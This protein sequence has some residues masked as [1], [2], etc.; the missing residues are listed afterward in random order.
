MNNIGNRITYVI[1]LLTLF[2]Y[3]GIADAAC[4]SGFID[5]SLGFCVM[6]YEAR[7]VGGVATSTTDGTPWTGIT[8]SDAIQECADIGAHL[9]TGQ[10]WTSIARDIEKVPSNWSDGVVGSGYLSRGYSASTSNA[11]D[12][13]TDT[14]MAPYT[15]TGYEYNTAADTVGPSG[16]FAL[17]RIHS[18]LNGQVIWD[19]AGN[20]WEWNNSTCNQSNW[21][22]SAGW[23][24]WNNV[25]LSDYELSAAGSSYGY[26]SDKNAGMYQGCIT[27]GNVFR[28]GGCRN[29]G[30]TAGIF[31]LSMDQSSTGATSVIGFRC[32]VETKTNGICGTVNGTEVAS[33]T[34]SSANLCSVGTVVSFGGTGPWTWNCAGY[35]GGKT[36]TCSADLS[37][38]IDTGLGFYVMKY[39]AKIQGLSDGN[40]T[41]ASSYI[42]ESRAS[43][44][45]WVNISQTNA[46]SECSSLGSGYHLITNDEWTALARNIESVSTNWSGGSIGLGAI[47]RGYSASETLGSGESFTNTVPASSTGDG[48][49]YN[50]GADIL[51]GSGNPLLKRTHLLSNG[52]L[53]WDLAGNAWEWNNGFCQ[54]GSGSNYWYDSSSNW[55]EWSNTNFDDYERNIAGPS[56]SS[57]VSGNGIGGVYGCAVD[58]NALLRGGVWYNGIRSGIYSLS[59]SNTAPTAVNA[60]FGFRC[61]KSMQPKNGACGSVDGTT[62]TAL[63]SISSGLCSYG[64]VVSF[65]GSGPWGWGCTGTDGGVTT[66]CS[67][68]KAVNGACGVAG[69]T[70]HSTLSSSSPNL[71]A[72]GSVSSFS[73]TGPWTWNCVGI[74]GGTSANC[75]ASLAGTSTCG[76][77]NGQDYLVEP[78]GLCSNGNPSLVVRDSSWK[79]SC[80]GEY[81]VAKSC[82]ELKA[83]GDNTNGVKQ[84]DPDGIGGND[85]IEV[86]CDMTTDGGGWTLIAAQYENDPVVDWNEGIQADYD[87]TLVVAKGFA[88]NNLQIPAHSQVAIGKF[89]G[90]LSILDYFDYSYNTGNIPVTLLH[91]KKLDKEYHVHRNASSFY[92]GHDPESLF[93]PS[94]G[95]VLW[96]NSLTFD[97]VGGVK[98]TWSFV[99]AY[100]YN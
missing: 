93:S 9:L 8:Q 48:Y 33:L 63:S 79:W 54:K 62:V 15:G 42:P 67:A 72:A 55:V 75:S 3:F 4:P 71:C 84:I 99:P 16:S 94:P 86:Y 1:S 13:F 30:L 52:K 80:Q 45:P 25:S 19:L 24:D 29:G 40:Q 68:T 17:K 22:S 82:S 89:D 38:W 35:H 73:G 76:A 91:G 61:A 36:A 88:L 87:P 44:T 51:G 10:E 69:S 2:F 18:L 100:D 7:N 37:N 39:E 59:F 92:T 81:P 78:T 23:I 43:G 96:N 74:E 21:Y 5:T 50:T 60:A 56:S 58:G 12:G 41:Y 57:Y 85:P 47:A 27:N 83:R 70:S 32:A 28:R 53:I 46:I 34:S 66:M 65:G 20:A 14:V 6:K 26:I 31:S 90:S 11:S 77:S 95:S 98:Y 64:N 97:E 49:E